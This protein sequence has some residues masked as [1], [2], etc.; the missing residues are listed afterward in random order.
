M[1]QTPSNIKHMVSVALRNTTAVLVFCLCSFLFFVKAKA[2]K[3]KPPVSR[4]KPLS[5]SPNEHSN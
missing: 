1:E 3:E 5:I 4:R 2:G